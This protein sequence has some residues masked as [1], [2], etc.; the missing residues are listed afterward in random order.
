MRGRS[1]ETR[2][3][4]VLWVGLGAASA[5]AV[6]L[7]GAGRAGARADGKPE[8]ARGVSEARAL[9]SSLEDQLRATEAS[10]KKARDLLA[11]LE[12]AAAPAAAP[13]KDA[14]AGADGD[15]TGLV[16]GV[17]RIVGVGGNNGGAFRKPPYDEYKIMSAGHYLWL[18]FDPATGNVLRSGGGEYRIQ[19]GTYTAFIEY[20]NSD[21]LRA[22]IGR[23]YTGTFKLD[24]KKWYHAGTVPNG[25]EFDELWERVH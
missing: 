23:E 9:V 20:S 3:V 2:S 17:W 12:G 15:Q 11:R 14:G 19:N 22:L 21:D 1:V 16:E 5:L 8:A 18:S 7:F 25:A 6:V 10:L 24:G 13:K 4:S